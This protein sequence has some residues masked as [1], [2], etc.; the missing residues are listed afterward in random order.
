MPDL[1]PLPDNVRLKPLTSTEALEFF[2]GKLD[3]QVTFSSDALWQA[4]HNITRTVSRLTSVITSYS[5]HYTKLYEAGLLP[6]ACLPFLWWSCWWAGAVSAGA[7]RWQ[8]TLAAPSK[9]ILRSG[10]L[11]LHVTSLG[12]DPKRTACMSQRPALHVVPE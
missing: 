6:L 11:K 2:R 12:L 1:I 3:T 8:Q 9:P 5:I 4:E 7:T 10:I